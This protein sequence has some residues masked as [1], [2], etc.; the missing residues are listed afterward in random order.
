MYKIGHEVVHPM[1]PRWITVVIFNDGWMHEAHVA[2]RKVDILGLANILKFSTRD[3][4]KTTVCSGFCVTFNLRL[5]L[6]FLF[7]KL[8]QLR[9]KGGY[10]AFFKSGA[11]AFGDG[12]QFEHAFPPV[13]FHKSD[14]SGLSFRIFFKKNKAR[15]GIFVGAR[16]SPTQNGFKSALRFQTRLNGSGTKSP[17]SRV[18][19]F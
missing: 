9:I 15:K 17:F 11:V 8:E 7:D 1:R 12:T 6:K 18:R 10:H 19:Y 3:V 13:E 2:L 4:Q 16:T 14:R 5:F